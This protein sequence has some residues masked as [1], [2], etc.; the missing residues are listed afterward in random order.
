MASVYFISK[1]IYLYFSIGNGQP[2]DP[3]LCQ[4]YRHTFDPH[5]DMTLADKGAE[6]EIASKY[7]GG[8]KC[9]GDNAGHG[10]VGQDIDRHD[11][12]NDLV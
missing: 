8:R 5:D 2:R 3:A 10:N 1:K 4:L 7:I 9:R 6:H 12:D 11:D